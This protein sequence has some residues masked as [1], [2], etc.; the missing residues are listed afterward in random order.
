MVY[1]MSNSLYKRIGVWFKRMGNLERNDDVVK[2]RMI[3]Y[4]QNDVKIKD[5]R[6]LVVYMLIIFAQIS[7]FGVG[8][9]RLS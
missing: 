9:G 4:N 8:V 3:F 5:L 2:P 1:G 6:E 7:D